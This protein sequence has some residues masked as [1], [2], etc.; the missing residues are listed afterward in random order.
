MLSVVVVSVGIV[1]DGP[2]AISP[3]FGSATLVSS[4]G[5][6]GVRDGPGATSPGFGRAI[7]PSLLVV[8]ELISNGGLVGSEDSVS[9]ERVSGINVSNT[10]ASFNS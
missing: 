1:R 2:G 3:G 6:D 8:T 9:S 4:S 5:T 7:A 10:A